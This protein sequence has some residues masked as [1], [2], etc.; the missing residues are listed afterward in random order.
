MKL[1]DF[2]GPVAVTLVLLIVG[3]AI[4]AVLQDRD[5]EETALRLGYLIMG[6]GAMLIIMLAWP[7]EAVERSDGV[8]YLPDFGD[9]TPYLG[10]IGYE[11]A[12]PSLVVADDKRPDVRADAMDGL[13]MFPHEPEPKPGEPNEVYRRRWIE[14]ACS[15][16]AANF[17][18]GW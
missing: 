5:L 1:R 17:H 15:L 3:T 11:A 8:H 4:V 18:P 7:D 12:A 9:T 10:V 2:G 13:F 16:P 6:A 14:W